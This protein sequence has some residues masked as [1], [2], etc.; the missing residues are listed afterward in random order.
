MDNQIKFLLGSIRPRDRKKAIEMLIKVGDEEALRALA[1]LYKTETDPEIK[2]LAIKAGKEIKRTTSTQEVSKILDKRTTQDRERSTQEVSKVP[3][4]RTTQERSILKTQSMRSLSSSTSQEIVRQEDEFKAVFVSPGRQ[5]Q[6]QELLES[7]RKLSADG[8]R[9]RALDSLVKAFKANPNYR[10]DSDALNLAANI[11]GYSKADFLEA[12]EDEARLRSLVKDVQT[13][14]EKK[15]NKAKSVSDTGEPDWRSIGIDLAIY[16]GVLA[17]VFIIFLLMASAIYQGAAATAA[18]RCDSCS[19]DDMN[20]LR[21]VVQQARSLL[22]YTPVQ[23]IL[24]GLIAAFAGLIETP[25]YFS[26][27]HVVARMMISSEGSYRGMYYY[28]AR[29]FMICFGIGITLWCIALLA[30]M[31][32]TFDVHYYQYY[33]YD[34]G[35]WV[36]RNLGIAGAIAIYGGGLWVLRRLM[37]YYSGG[38]FQTG[39]ATYVAYVISSWILGTLLT[40]LFGKIIPPALLAIIK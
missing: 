19:I 31:I 16:Y 18:Q 25:L 22:N 21:D 33:I 35:D 10:M 17:T 38:C 5:A 2:E 14:K 37:N 4:K 15:K 7:A 27:L 9:I 13:Q 3:E 28:C 11:T 29:F 6:A 1:S 32:Q 30:F 39:C 40:G 26:V 24:Y 12:L 23:A 20:R 36:W 34:K 8:S